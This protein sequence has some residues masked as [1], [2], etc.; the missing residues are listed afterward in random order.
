MSTGKREPRLFYVSIL[1]GFWLRRI[2]QEPVVPPAV[3]QRPTPLLGSPRRPRRQRCAPGHGGHVCGRADEANR[4]GNQG[5]R[6]GNA[7]RRGEEYTLILFND[8]S[9]Q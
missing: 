9:T 6:I 2:G 3:R 1:L 7:R 5:E 4:G 8:S